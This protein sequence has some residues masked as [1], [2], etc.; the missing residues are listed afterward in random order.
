MDGDGA[1]ST[2][3][4]GVIALDILLTELAAASRFRFDVK[5]DGDVYIDDH[6]TAED[7][8][9]TIGQCLNQA[10]GDKKGLAR[11]ACATASRGQATVRAVVDLSNR[12]HFETNMALDQEFVESDSAGAVCGARLSCEMVLHV[13]ESIVVEAR[14]TVHLEE[15]AT[16]DA[17]DVTRAEYMTG[18]DRR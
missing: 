7:V 10:L 17:I 3:S 11:M 8:G 14:S 6:H 4:T 16:G 1:A 9:I 15:L 13:F 2:I 5:C 18:G 12:P